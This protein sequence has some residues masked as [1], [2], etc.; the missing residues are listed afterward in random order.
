MAATLDARVSIYIEANH[1]GRMTGADGGY[2]VCGEKYVPKG[3][4]VSYT[5]QRKADNVLY[6]PVA[7]D[8]VIE[9]LATGNPEIVMTRKIG[10]YLAAGTLVWVADPEFETV[11]VYTPGQPRQ[12]LRV[13]DVLEG[14][15]V[16]PGFTLAV[17]DIFHD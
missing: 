8:L 12:T 5:R 16:L 2:V 10:N 13:G 9:V 17:A 11:D 15:E 7:P 3:A 4:F 1:L 14:G 6:N